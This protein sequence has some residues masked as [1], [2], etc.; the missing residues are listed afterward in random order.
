M[1]EG[2]VAMITGATGGLGRVLVPDLD[3]DG[4]DLV[5]VGSSQK[6]LDALI[7]DAESR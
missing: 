5:L 4:W 3:A 2:R 6:R 7:T 1:T